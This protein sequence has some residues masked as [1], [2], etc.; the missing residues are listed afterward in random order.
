MGVCLMNE[1]ARRSDLY[2][3][4]VR[5]TETCTIYD[6]CPEQTK[7]NSNATKSPW[8]K[9]PARRRSDLTRT[10]RLS[11][12]PSQTSGAN[13]PDGTHP[14]VGDAGD[15]GTAVPIIVSDPSL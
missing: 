4:M 13:S 7:K 11:L 8:R 14:P 1:L 15:R 2:A 12:L 6:N 10:T 5:E 3:Q 9:Y